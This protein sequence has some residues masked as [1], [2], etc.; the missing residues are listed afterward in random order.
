[1]FTMSLV[2]VYPFVS[3]QSV[4]TKKKEYEHEQES[5]I[6]FHFRMVLFSCV[7][8]WG[9]WKVKKWNPLPRSVFKSIK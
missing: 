3:V 4:L 1:M 8:E 7:K 9:I 5:A 6:I 2:S